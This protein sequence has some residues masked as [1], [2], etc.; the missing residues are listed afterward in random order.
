MFVPLNEI[1]EEICNEE[2]LNYC[3]SDLKSEWSREVIGKRKHVNKT[4]ITY[5]KKNENIKNRFPFALC[6]NDQVAFNK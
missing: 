4:R 6:T 1:E 3:I 5:H 2:I